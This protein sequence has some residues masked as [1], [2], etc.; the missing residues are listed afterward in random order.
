MSSPELANVKIIGPLG[1]NIGLV[2]VRPMPD[3]ALRATLIAALQ[4][5]P[6]LDEVHIVETPLRLVAKAGPG[7]MHD[8]HARYWLQHGRMQPD[9][10]FPIEVQWEPARNN[11]L[12]TFQVVGFS[13]MEGQ[14]A[15]AE[16]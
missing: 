2:N 14:S 5:L 6:V 12:H 1:R 8:P 3:S 13:P 10:A 11:R 7:V 9:F 16:E 4:T 15:S